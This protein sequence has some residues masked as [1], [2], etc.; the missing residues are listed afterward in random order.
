MFNLVSCCNKKGLK[1]C[2]MTPIVFTNVDIF[3]AYFSHLHKTGCS[4]NTS[5][6]LIS[7]SIITITINVIVLRVE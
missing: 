4:L 2:V 1:N 3:G 5:K 7:I 6:Y